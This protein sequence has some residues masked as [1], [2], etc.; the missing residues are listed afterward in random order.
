MFSVWKIVT[1]G[2]ISRNY[3]YFFILQ[4]IL[5]IYLTE[6]ERE[7]ERTSRGNS[8]QRE[9][10]KQASCWARNP[11]WGWIPGPRDHDLSQRQTLNRLSQPG[12][13]QKPHFFLTSY[14]FFLRFIYLFMIEIETQRERQRHRRREKQAPCR[15]PYA[16]LD[17]G[18]EDCTLGQRQVL[19]HWAT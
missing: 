1:C 11:M 12:A 4:N 6:R 19:N 17:P 9:R 8:R 7:R 14:L 3:F 5:F 15:E 2:K 13:P 18:T 16:G 10:E